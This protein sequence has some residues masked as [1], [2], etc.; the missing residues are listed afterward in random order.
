MRKESEERQK[1]GFMQR[2][3]RARTCTVVQVVRVNSLQQTRPG[4]LKQKTN[5]GLGFSVP[6]RPPRSV[7]GLGNEAEGRVKDKC[8]GSCTACQDRVCIVIWCVGVQ[9]LEQDLAPSSRLSH[10]PNPPTSHTF[11]PPTHTHSCAYLHVVER[12]RCSTL[13]RR[14]A[15]HLP[16]VRAQ[17]VQRGKG[18]AG[19]L[20]HALAAPGG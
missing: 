1:Q 2:V 8:H 3:C 9:G 10:L 11:L 6:C 4:G 12:S 18:V 15:Q 17:L 20:Q 13:Q 7:S 16:H 14:A 5:R 19:Q